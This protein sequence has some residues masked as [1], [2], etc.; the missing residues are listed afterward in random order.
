M[1]LVAAVLICLTFA[2]HAH[3]HAFYVGFSVI[4]YNEETRN[5]EVIHRLFTDDLARVVTGDPAAPVDAATEP[6]VS[7][8][9]QDVFQIEQVPLSW[10]G[11]EADADMT[12]IYMESP[13]AEPPTELTISNTLMFGFFGQQVNA[14]NMMVGGEIRALSFV[15][16]LQEPR[17]KTAVFD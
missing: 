5:L 6:R 7:A 1:R 14:V 8:Y 2:S 10:V 16:M 3:G 17:T 4:S 11:M 9:I 15:E 12:L 13:M